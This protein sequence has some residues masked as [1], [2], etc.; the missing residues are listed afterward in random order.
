MILDLDVFDTCLPAVGVLCHASIDNLNAEVRARSRK[1]RVKRS[2]PRVN[3]RIR[4]RHDQASGSLKRSIQD[5]HFPNQR[6][7]PALLVLSVLPCGIADW[8]IST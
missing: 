4:H 2:N 3:T 7:C 8:L 1:D 6:T 5:V